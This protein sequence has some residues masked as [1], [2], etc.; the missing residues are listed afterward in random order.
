MNPHLDLIGTPRYPLNVKMQYR[1]IFA[2]DGTRPIEDEGLAA[3]MRKVHEKVP[4]KSGLCYG[5]TERVVCN[6]AENGW[7]GIRAYAGW[8]MVKDEP[9]VHHSW[10]VLNGQVIDFSFVVIP[11]EVLTKFNE[12]WG[13]RGQAYYARSKGTGQLDQEWISFQLE[14]RKAFLDLNNDY[15]RG[16]IIPN[17]VFGKIPSIITYCGSPCSPDEARRIFNI[18]HPIYVKDHDGPGEASVIQLLGKGDDEGAKK[19]LAEILKGLKK[20]D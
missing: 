15:E 5:N 20:T 14:S 17:R 19:K 6:A 8:I 9:P 3:L 18:W 13:R 12:E 4:F 2:A 16:D 11:M 1:T 10:A 7:S